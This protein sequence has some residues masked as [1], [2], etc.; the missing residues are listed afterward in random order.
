MRHLTYATLSQKNCVQNY[1]F[2]SVWNANLIFFKLDFF[3]SL[4]TCKL[5]YATFD[6]CNIRHMQHLTDSKFDRCGIWLYEKFDSLASDEGI[7]FGSYGRCNGQTILSEAEKA[8]YSFT[9]L[10]PNKFVK[11]I[12]RY[13][14]DLNQE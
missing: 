13:R 5:T 6:K 10:M 9:G 3:V 4:I 1:G 2:L 7:D 11:V 8:F 12:S 14:I